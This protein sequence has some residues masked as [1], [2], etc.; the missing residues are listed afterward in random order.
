MR[1][2]EH[3]MQEINRLVHEPARLRALTLLSSVKEAEFSFILRALGLTNGN[4]SV[5]M[6][7]LEDAGYVSMTK[8]F[9]GRVPKTM[10]SIT[11]R[12]RRALEKYWRT[13]D[14][15]RADGGGSPGP[16]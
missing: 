11:T 14:E 13:L 9:V 7:R 15:L 1:G 12:G 5:H 3:E 8:T 16:Q 4:L 2:R 6:R 10:F